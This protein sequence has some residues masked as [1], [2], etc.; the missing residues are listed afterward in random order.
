MFGQKEAI[1]KGAGFMMAEGPR[2]APYGQAVERNKSP[3]KGGYHE[4]YC[5]GISGHVLY[6]SGNERE[7]EGAVSGCHEIM[8]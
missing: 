2:D 7:E 8:P 1:E 5:I 6:R 4:H 3:A